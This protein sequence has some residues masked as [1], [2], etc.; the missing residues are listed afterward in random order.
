MVKHRK[1]SY[2]FRGITAIERSHC[3]LLESEVPDYSGATGGNVA[4][5]CAEAKR[6]E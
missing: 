1:D 2:S 6:L 5:C 4:Y 3:R